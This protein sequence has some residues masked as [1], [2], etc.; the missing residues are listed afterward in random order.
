MNII[1]KYPQGYWQSAD[2]KFINK[3]QALLHA[4][5][6]NLPLPKYKFFDSVWENFDRSLLGTLSLNELYRQ[7]AQQLRDKYD[8]LILY[9]SG[10]ADSYNVLRSFIDNGIKLDEVCVKWCT[11]TVSNKDI[12]IPN[13]T[14]KTAYNF[15]SEWDYAISPVLVELAQTYPDIKIEIVDWFKDKTLSGSE[16]I[17]AKVNHYHEIE[18]ASLAIWSPTE[19][20][21]LEKGKTVGSI[22]GIDKPTIWFNDEGAYL[23][24]TD[25]A[26]AMGTPN[27]DNIYGTEYFYYA[28]ELP[29]L[30]FEM[31]YCALRAFTEDI[32]LG[33]V[34]YNSSVRSN[35]L[36]FI[37]AYQQQQKRLRSVLYDSWTDR[38]QVDKSIIAD[39]SDK[40]NWIF[41]NPELSFYKDNYQDMIK[42]HINSISKD[43]CTI[44]GGVVG[45]KLIPTKLFPLF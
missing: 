4:T 21:M 22:Y 41:K 43:F 40:H 37:T 9:F 25:A 14:D 10:G 33:K 13:I 26:T 44:E 12:Y 34:K 17:F 5:D 18:I 38:F 15:L 39:R 28:P 20:I 11:D 16:E 6:N 32:E 29:L 45:Y 2:Q 36:A 35:P 30:T 42:R 8:Y 24:F 1:E 19:E 31:A 3:Y 27:P 23:F 7:R